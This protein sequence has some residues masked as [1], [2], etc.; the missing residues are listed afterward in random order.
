MYSDVPTVLDSEEPAD[1]SAFADL[2]TLLLLDAPIEDT[3]ASIE[4]TGAPIGGPLPDRGFEDLGAYR[5]EID[6]A[7][8]ILT[9]QLGV[10]TDEAFVRL[11]ACTRLQGRRLTGVAADVVDHRLRSSPDAEPERTD[12]GT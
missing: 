10:G 1:A 2:A 8:G 6:R 9:V 12:E 11:R 4:E 3:G 7:T 5:A